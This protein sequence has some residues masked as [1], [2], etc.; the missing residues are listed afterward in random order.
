MRILIYALGGGLGHATRALSLARALLRRRG[1]VRVCILSNSALARR[2]IPEAPGRQL[3]LRFFDP[4]WDKTRVAAALAP[5]FS[6][7]GFA[8]LVVD[9]F[10]RGLGGELVGLLDAVACPKALVHRCLPRAYVARFDLASFVAERYDAVILPG[11]D[12]PLAGLKR[13][14]R[15]EPWLICQA[16]EM[17]P[18]EEVR[19]ALGVEDDEK[20][21]AVIGCGTAEEIEE[22]RRLARR[23]EGAG[24]A[25]RLFTPFDE[26]PRWPLFEDFLGFDAIV[27]A[28][29][30]NTVHEARA[31]RRPL[32]SLPRRRLYDDQA[33]RLSA[34]ERLEDD[35]GLEARLAAALASVA[36]QVLAPQVLAFENGADRAAE[37]ILDPELGAR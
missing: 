37:L 27:G 8:R 29:G 31:A 36:P 34:A 7:G 4:A 16:D 28:G 17:R 11:E 32:L 14:R 25:V 21:V 15:T 10:P 26:A 12:A 20:L 23:I 18:R 35:M 30:Y 3:E 22:A 6:A 19:R 33:G 1:E 13:A 9:T 5:I 2:L 24:R